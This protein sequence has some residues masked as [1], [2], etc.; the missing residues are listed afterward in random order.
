MNWSEV[1]LEVALVQLSGSVEWPPAPDVVDRVRARIG[2]RPISSHP[3]WRSRITLAAAAAAVGV[4]GALLSTPGFRAAAADFLGLGR[5]KIETGATVPT[6]TTT[7]P[8]L[9]LGRVSSLEEVDEIFGHVE[10][11]AL[12]GAPDAVYL[13]D[14]HEFSAL[15]Y[16][17]SAELPEIGDTG[18]GLIIFRLPDSPSESDPYLEKF[19]GGDAH[20][21]R[22]KVKGVEGL[23]VRGF[24]H[25][26]SFE[27]STRIS[28]NALIWESAGVTF[29]IESMM[30]LREVLGIARSLE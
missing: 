17:A 26:L 11:P 21:R 4:F 9:G 28:G 3:V 12:L 14:F 8:D 15:V 19:P 16:D 29:R 6:P 5:V 30:T 24:E 25:A 13:S 27:D 7:A 10:V 18:A 23:W 1:N 22:V 20:V 2:V